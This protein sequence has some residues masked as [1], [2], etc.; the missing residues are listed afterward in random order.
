M[1]IWYYA[2]G[3]AGMRGRERSRM[4]NR[5]H[6]TRGICAVLSFSSSVHVRRPTCD[7]TS[8]AGPGLS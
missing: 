3:A 5:D 7:S 2:R 6:S 1:Y 8:T 4:G